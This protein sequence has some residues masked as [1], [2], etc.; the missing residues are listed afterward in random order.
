MAAE[1][2]IIE[3]K[4]P[5]D[6]FEAR[7]ESKLLSEVLDRYGVQAVYREVLDA[8]H[9]ARSLRLGARPYI[10]YVHI[11]C[12]GSRD[13]ICLSDGTFI[14]WQAFDSLGWPHLRRTCLAFSACDVSKGVETLYS[15]HRTFCNAI[16]AP[17]REIT[18]P[19]GLVAFAAFYYRATFCEDSNAASDVRVMNHIVGRGT[20][21]LHVS[22]RSSATFLLGMGQA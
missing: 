7:G 1:V 12:H 8:K 17:I 16:V 3:S 2:L 4:N 18:W 21:R 15:L 9:L 11:S 5:S 6:H 22:P 19:A 13:G 14:D 20:F 10:A